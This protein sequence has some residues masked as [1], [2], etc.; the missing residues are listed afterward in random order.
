MKKT[1][2]RKHRING[3]YAYNDTDRFFAEALQT[4]HDHLC[5]VIGVNVPLML[6]RKHVW[7]PN[8]RYYGCYRPLQTQCVWNFS[9][10]YGNT[11]RESLETI[12]HELRHALQFQEGW[13]TGHTERRQRWGKQLIGVWKGEEYQGDY[14]NAPWEIDARAFQQCYAQSCF[15]L[16]TQ[17]ELDTVLPTYVPKYPKKK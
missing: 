13:Y 2:I 16:F 3:I 1:R 12:G 6:E 10:N 5:Q 15:G 4:A 9:A 14:F 11:L 7:G 17:E 8:A